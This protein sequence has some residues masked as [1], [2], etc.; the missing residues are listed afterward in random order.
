MQ[1]VG[2]EEALTILA[3]SID[4][5]DP[6]CMLE[7][8]KLMAAIC[9]VPPDGQVFHLYLLTVYFA[10]ATWRMYWILI[11]MFW[12]LPAVNHLFPIYYSR[13]CRSSINGLVQ[14]KFHC[15]SVGRSVDL[16]VDNEIVSSKNCL[17]TIYRYRLGWWVGWTEEIII[18]WGLNLPR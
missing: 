1:M 16:S 4:P 9:L 18:T 13:L 17:L 10:S 3:R 5:R 11:P 2:H 7:A 8:V 6:T 14:V 15:R 12:C